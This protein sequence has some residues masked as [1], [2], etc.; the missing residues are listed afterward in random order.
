M[1]R[2]V[3]LIVEDDIPDNV[4]ATSYA[5][6]GE[7]ITMGNGRTWS[8]VGKVLSVYSSVHEKPPKAV[9]DSYVMGGI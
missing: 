5:V 9:T 2:L 8:F 4:V 3:V 6:P 1:K 7:C